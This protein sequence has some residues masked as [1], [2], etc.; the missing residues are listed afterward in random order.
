MT[1]DELLAR[2][3][4]AEDKVR[5][6]S[7]LFIP[8]ERGLTYLMHPGFSFPDHKLPSAPIDAA[9]QRLHKRGHLAYV[10]RTRSLMVTEE[11]HAYCEQNNH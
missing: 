5:N 3:C 7:F 1:D 8:G 11:G 6:K 4:E 2:M 10:Q 9:L